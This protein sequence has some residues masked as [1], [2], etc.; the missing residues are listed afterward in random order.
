MLLFYN[1]KT[2]YRAAAGSRRI[3][4][5]KHPY[6]SGFSGAVGAQE[7]KDFPF[8]HFE[9]DMIDCGETSEFLFQVLYLYGDVIAF[10]NA[11]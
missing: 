3:N 5:A 2:A 9:I 7:A 6:G 1:I 11:F 10:H 8:F 4:T